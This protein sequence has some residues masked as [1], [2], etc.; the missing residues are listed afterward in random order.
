VKKLAVGDVLQADVAIGPLIDEIAE[1]KVQ[2]HHAE[3]LEKGARVITGRE[4][5]NLGGNYLQPTIQQDLPH[6]A[7]LAKEETYG[8]HAPLY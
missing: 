3:P 2:E 8:P 4:A 7:K 5:P 6:N 1:A